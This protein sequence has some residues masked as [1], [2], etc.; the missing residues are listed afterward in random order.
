[1]RSILPKLKLHVTFL[2]R[3][4]LHLRSYCSYGSV[5]LCTIQIFRPQ[6]AELI[7]YSKPQGSTSKDVVGQLYG[8]STLAPKLPSIALPLAGK[9][10]N[11]SLPA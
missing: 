1:M 10:R 3:A 2:I 9:K 5:G 7:E 6:L 4:V 11:M 8:L